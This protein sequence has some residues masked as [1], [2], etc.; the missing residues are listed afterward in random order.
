MAGQDLGPDEEFHSITA[1]LDEAFTDV[2]CAVC[3][4][5]EHVRSVAHAAEHCMVT[6]HTVVERH[7]AVMTFRESVPVG[8]AA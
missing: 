3:G 4:P 5:I 2:I 1:Q 8:G 7:V 6:G